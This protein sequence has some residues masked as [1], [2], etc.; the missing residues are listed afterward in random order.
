MI[1]FIKFLNNYR[2]ALLGLP[3]LRFQPEVARTKRKLACAS[4]LFVWN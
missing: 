3:K 2:K 1:L 4:F